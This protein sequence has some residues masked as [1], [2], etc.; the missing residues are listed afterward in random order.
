MD[1][2]KSWTII[3]QINFVCGCILRFIILLW[4]Q[5]TEQGDPYTVVLSKQGWNQGVLIHL[6]ISCHLPPLGVVSYMRIL[7]W[8][9]LSEH[10]QQLWIQRTKQHTCDIHVLQNICHHYF[11]FSLRLQLLQLFPKLHGFNKNPF[12]THTIFRLVNAS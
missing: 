10:E 12:V 9:S 3:Q 6:A 7:S 11:L 5:S 8:M 1:N 2:K 4:V